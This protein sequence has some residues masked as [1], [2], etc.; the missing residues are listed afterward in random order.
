MHLTRWKCLDRH[1]ATIV[2]QIDTMETKTEPL[3]DLTLNDQFTNASNKPSTSASCATEVQS[4]DLLDCLLSP[5]ASVDRL[6][7]MSPCQQ[8]SVPEY[9]AGAGAEGVYAAETYH[10]RQSIPST[11]ASGLSSPVACSPVWSHCSATAA[12]DVNARTCSSSASPPSTHAWIATGEAPPSC[13][14]PFTVPSASQ[15]HPISAP[16]ASI[17]ESKHVA[18]SPSPEPSTRSSTTDVS[19]VSS[20]N[21]LHGRR[22]GARVRLE[23]LFDVEAGVTNDGTPNNNTDQACT[24]FLNPM[25]I[26]SDFDTS[27][28]TVGVNVMDSGKC[29]S[30]SLIPSSGRSSDVALSWKPSCN[31]RAGPGGAY[32]SPSAT[33]YV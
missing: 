25:A 26:F 5:E 13:S 2:T 8:Q 27:S 9:G 15:Q 24:G 33:R 20:A 21:D 7:G 32:Q 17:Q 16:L 12:D 10:S 23:D 1:G 14:N 31:S 18:D 19:E 4:K 30:Q 11:P 3:L 22:Q 6:T 29:E 28:S